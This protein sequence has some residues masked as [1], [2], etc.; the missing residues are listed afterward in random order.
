VR[1]A[2][3]AA[4]PAGPANRIAEIRNRPAAP[5]ADLVAKH[6]QAAEAATPDGAGGNHAATRPVSV[7]RRR[8]FDRVAIAI[9]LDNERRVIEVAA[10]PM[11]PRG[12][13]GLEDAAVEADGVTTSAERN[14]IQI[15]GCRAQRLHRCREASPAERRSASGLAHTASADCPQTGRQSRLHRRARHAA[16]VDNP[17]RGSTHPEPRRRAA[18]YRALRHSPAE[19]P[20]CSWQAIA[21]A[22]AMRGKRGTAGHGAHA[23]PMQEPG[24]EGL[25]RA[26]LVVRSESPRRAAGDV[27]LR[28]E[29]GSRE[30]R[31]RGWHGGPRSRARADRPRA[32]P[33]PRPRCGGR[34]RRP[35]AQPRLWLTTSTLWPSGSSTKA[36]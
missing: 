11:L 19:P 20:G 14:P 35:S 32:P 26:M 27:C 21:R 33:G 36:P 9:Q 6:A 31:A 13:N 22:E 24:Q 25:G 10:L 18:P 8:D 2:R 16:A 1:D 28:P 29:S 12:V 17:T 30:C 4:E 7:R 23:L 3:L 5:A 15:H 34:S